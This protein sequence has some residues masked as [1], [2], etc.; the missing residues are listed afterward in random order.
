MSAG[1]SR[2]LF[3]FGLFEADLDNAALT[4]KGV[5]VRL[6]HQP[7][8]ILAML[9]EHSDQIVTREELRQ[10]L[11][12]A[13][14]YV[15]FDASL[16]MALKRLRS[17]LGD[18][19]DNPRFI[20]TIPKRGYR[21]IVP[22]SG[23]GA[24]E[25]GTEESVAATAAASSPM[26][27]AAPA[28]DLGPARVAFLNRRAILAITAIAAAIS[29]AAFFAVHR[30]R[31]QPPAFADA[32]AVDIGSLGR[33][34]AVLG[35]QNA[36]GRPS[37]SWLATALA[38]M[39][40]TELGAGGKLR[41]VPGESVAQFRAGA[42]WLRTDS[43]SRRTALRVGK[44]LDSNLL[45]LGSF[46]TVGDQQNG[47]V[48]VD[49]RLQDAQ[50]GEI[51]YEGAESGDE[52]QLFG[53]VATVGADLRERLG[54]PM[55]S[56]SEEAGVVSSLPS[57]PDA[58][59]LYSLGL[60]KLRDADFAAAKDLFLQTEKLSARFPLVHL[61]LFRAW[62][63][64]G[65][66]QKAKREIR[67][68]YELSSGLAEVDRLQVEGAYYGS[69]PE[70]DKSI[71]A[72]RALCALYPDSVDYAEQLVIALNAA[73][74]NEEAL[75]VI[76]NLRKLPPPASEDP[77][78][79]FWEGQ[80]ISETNKAGAQV[81]LEKAS[82]GAA[83]RGETLLYAR[84]RLS[85]CIDVTYSD[86]PQGAMKLCKE[87]YDTFM[88]AGNRMY[89]ADALRTMGDRRGAEGDLDGARELY[90]RAVALLVPL[91]EHEKIG[92]VFNNMAIGYEYQG[93]IAQAEKLLRQAALT[94]T[95]CGDLLHAGAALGNIAD[96]LMMRGRLQEAED[97]YK[98]A[99]KQIEAI[100]PNDVADE[101][102]NIAMIRLYEGDM[103]GAKLFSA[104]ALA[105]AH[106]RKD[107][108]DIAGADQVLGTIEIAADDLAA[109]HDS[110]Q[111]SL[112]LLQSRGQ[113]IGIAES[114]AGLAE[115]SLEAGK[116]YK[117][118]QALRKALDEFR[119]GKAVND[120]IQTETDLSRALLAQGKLTGA[121]ETISNAMALSASSAD[122]NLKLPVAIMDARIQEAELSASASAK[123]K[124]NF[125]VP[126]H[127]F[128]S[129][130]AT[131]RQLG[132]YQL[133]CEARLALGELD[134]RDDASGAR[135]QL[136]ELA[137]NA[138]AHG[139]TLVARKAATVTDFA[140]SPK[141]RASDLP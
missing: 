56:E 30:S 10:E 33:S 87:A 137:R 128:L 35:F 82:A 112:N 104:Q 125:S 97:Q 58:N 52:R 103:A 85:E 95:E 25:P 40:R 34:V 14:T 84:F 1:K 55:I 116:P 22:V 18:D 86:H 16:N 117:A 13:G 141:D 37:D 91:G 19:A 43:L 113:K 135:S 9:L 49:F 90:Q 129:V 31:V 51:L 3:R 45:V 48:R 83:S 99:Q 70:R 12:P 5:R 42:P 65:Y 109:A 106:R 17:A 68:A 115:V 98:K 72:Y 15:S 39:L 124:P 114:E 93:Q 134:V 74:R 105:V 81:L 47:S 2:R 123:S 54:L 136:A 89:A 133:E 76:H 7:F 66:D 118:E 46:A 88:S 131:A 121:R 120:E 38:E 94:W 96:I 21:F 50:T 110:F 69:I 102:Y 75:A 78:I 59:R 8:R 101:L 139:L 126:R 92:V 132:Y 119:V 62:G 61:M 122:P 138:R 77:R 29:L 41:V 127:E 36:S 26:L 53:L 24:R 140:A 100:D 32:K 108:Q 44:A 28:G 73:G 20:E 80:L 60:E 27:T 130:I 63:G 64:L 71:S 4:R 57:D 111:E 67:T 107:N 23:E 6:Q 11:W 79:D